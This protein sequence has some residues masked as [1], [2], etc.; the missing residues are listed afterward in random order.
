M[1]LLNERRTV[2]AP[3]YPGYG[4]SS[5][6]GQPV[7]IEHYANAINSL[8]GA[9]ELKDIAV[10]GFHTGCLVGAELALRQS[11]YVTQLIL[12]DVPYFNS[13]ERASLL[14]QNS[15]P[16]HWSGELESIRPDWEFAVSK[17]LGSMPFSR[18]LELFS[19]SMR[20]GLHKNDGFKAAFSY[21]CEERFAKIDVTT[22]L[23]ATKS[24]LAEATREAA[25]HVRD[26]R[27][28]ELESIRRAA[29][30]ESAETIATV[31]AEILDRED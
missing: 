27:L 25:K 22:E 21:R 3:D 14:A 12:I 1:P 6:L 28:V 15:A 29:F 11:S 30:E 17:R 23:I 10:L 5:R 24:A 4:G 31:V 20:A 8:V 7:S 16:P 18:A 13:T 2:F 19:E 9:L 26:S